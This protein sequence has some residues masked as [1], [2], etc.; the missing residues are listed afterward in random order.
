MDLPLLHVTCRDLHP[1]CRHDLWGRSPEDVVLAY[2][3]HHRAE[4]LGDEADL[5]H[6]LSRVTLCRPGAQHGRADAVTPA[7]PGGAPRGARVLTP[8]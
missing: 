2:V 5:D 1:G 3:L 8:G 7:V 6:L 4:H